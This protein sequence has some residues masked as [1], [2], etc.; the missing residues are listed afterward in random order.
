MQPPD[1]NLEGERS[2]RAKLIKVGRKRERGGGERG[3]E[4]ENEREGERE[5][6]RE[7]G[8]RRENEREGERERARERRGER[9]REP[10]V[11]GYITISIFLA[12]ASC[13]YL[14]L[15]LSLLPL[16]FVSVAWGWFYL[17]A[18]FLISGFEVSFFLS[19]TC[20]CT[21]IISLAKGHGTTGDRC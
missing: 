12:L 5:R 20:N 10:L 19:L 11:S 1:E 4:R 14:K 15:P 7:R 21:H 2:T 3:G 18:G 13:L 6:R 17:P 16:F 9:D 8:R